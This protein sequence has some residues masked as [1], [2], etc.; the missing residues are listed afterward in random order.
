M[1]LGTGQE[2]L[3]CRVLGDDGATAFG[4]S[5]QLDAT[6]ARHIALYNA[7]LRSERPRI[8]PVIGHP[9]ETA[10]VAGQPI[11]WESE[12]AFTRLEWLP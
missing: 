5:L 6:E 1:R 11:A 7:G 10:W 9:W 3:V 2:A 12:P 4:F 8:T